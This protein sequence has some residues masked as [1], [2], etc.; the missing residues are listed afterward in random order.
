MFAQAWV[1]EDHW[2]AAGE[3]HLKVEIIMK[4]HKHLQP[5][6]LSRGN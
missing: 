3:N 5:R 2:A 6:N 1:H 4:A